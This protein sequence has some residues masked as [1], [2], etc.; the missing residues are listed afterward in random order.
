MELSRP[1]AAVLRHATSADTSLFAG[2]AVR[3]GKSY[4]V[5][6]SFAVWL[7]GQSKPFDHAIVGQSIEAIM[8]NCGRDLIDAL[9]SMTGVHAYLDRQIGTRIIVRGQAEQSV[10]LIGA[11]DA[12][13]RRRIQGATLKGLVVEELALLPEDFF[14]MAWSRLSVDGAKMWC[15]FNPEG[16]AHWAKRR[17]IDKAEDYEGTV[18]RFLMRD[19]PT[20]S[21][22]VIERYERSFTGHFYQRLIAGEWAAAEGACYAEWGVTKED[23]EGVWAL[24]F[25]WAFSGTMAA[26]AI[27]SRGRQATVAHELYHEGR[28]AGL[29]NEA[30]TAERI[31][32]WWGEVTGAGTGVMWVDPATPNS[33]KQRMRRAGFSVRNADNDVVPGIVTTAS[34]LASGDVLIHERCETLQTELAGYVWDGVASD[35][36][37]DKPVKK[38]DHGADALRYWAH[39]TGKHLRYLRPTS[40]ERALQ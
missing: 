29:L 20:L 31:V 27:C 36:G 26:L 34:R 28:S 10:W 16:P 1:Q 4:S 22:E 14:N 32:T 38:A 33:F 39:S 23:P 12:K 6:L 2:G 9:N 37:E 24:A 40:V 11:N 17:V 19:N 25:D 3:S 8:R 35:K 21:K 15:S 18:L 13:A 7:V 5:L 30:Q